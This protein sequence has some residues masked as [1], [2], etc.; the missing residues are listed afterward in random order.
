MPP[1]MFC[2]LSFL[3]YKSVLADGDGFQGTLTVGLGQSQ[4]FCFLLGPSKIVLCVFEA[5]T[6]IVINMVLALVKARMPHGWG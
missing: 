2:G 6:I 5:S 1:L 3:E 4:R